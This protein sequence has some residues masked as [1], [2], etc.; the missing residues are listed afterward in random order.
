MTKKG[1]EK[2]ARK[3][4]EPDIFTLDNG[5]SWA[6]KR[7]E[8]SVVYTELEGDYGPVAGLVVT[9]GKCGHAEEAFGTSL[10]SVGFACVKLRNNCPEGISN[11]Y[12]VPR[13]Q[14]RD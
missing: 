7:I 13:S 6:G 5:P 1:I 2:M 12:C 10:R 3:K 9:C 8:C 11:F 14:C 4:L